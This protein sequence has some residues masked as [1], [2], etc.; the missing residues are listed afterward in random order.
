MIEHFQGINGVSII[1]DDC[2]VEGFGNNSDQASN[3]HNQNLRAYLQ[4]FIERNIKIN[5]DKCKF[6]TEEVTYMGHTL[7]NTG[8]KPDEE[9]YGQS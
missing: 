4:R 2:L 8:L 3:N 1:Q 7:T 9:K 5:L 6:L